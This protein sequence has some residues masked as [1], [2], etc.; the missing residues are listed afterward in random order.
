ME[1]FSSQDL[2]SSFLALSSALGHCKRSLLC[3][4]S[5]FLSFFLSELNLIDYF[6][7][8]NSKERRGVRLLPVRAREA[9]GG[10]GGELID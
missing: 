4:L 7:D 8:S 10:G 5:G 6:W 1:S 3:V 9:L 2:E